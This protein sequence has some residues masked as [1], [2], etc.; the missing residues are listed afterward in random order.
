MATAECC[1]LS[2]HEQRVLE[3]QQGIQSYAGRERVFAILNSFK[4]TR[5]TIDVERAALF[6]ESMRQTEGEHLTLRWAKAIKHIAENI[7]VY[8]D[9]QL[10]VGR[11]GCR[12][13]WNPVSGT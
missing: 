2:P 4:G 13:I 5:P 8:N 9:H 11:S 6:T 7:I 10:L 3:E 1:I 12:T